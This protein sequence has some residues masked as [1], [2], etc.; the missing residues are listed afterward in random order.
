LD[1]FYKLKYHLDSNE[2][3]PKFSGN[4]QLFGVVF[5]QISEVFSW[6]AKYNFYGSGK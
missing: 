3:V 4:L 6:Y 5:V 1:K 2:V